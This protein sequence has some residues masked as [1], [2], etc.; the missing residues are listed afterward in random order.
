M[1]GFGEGFQMIRCLYELGDSKTRST[2]N[3]KDIKSIKIE[4]CQTSS[5]YLLR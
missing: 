1:G 5:M 2:W 3:K 4:V